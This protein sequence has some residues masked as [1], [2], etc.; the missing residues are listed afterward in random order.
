MDHRD[1]DREMP[2]CITTPC[3]PTKPL[4]GTCHLTLEGRLQ[5]PGG[6]QPPFLL[7]TG[8]RQRASHGCRSPQPH[9]RRRPAANLTAKSML[10]C[11]SRPWSECGS[12]RS[13]GKAPT[14]AHCQHS[15]ALRRIL[16]IS[17]SCVCNDRQ[18]R[19]TKP[20]TAVSSSCQ[21]LQ[22]VL[23]WPNTTA[24]TW[25]GQKYTTKV[26]NF[27]L[28]L[29]RGGKRSPN[30]VSGSPKRYSWFGFNSR[31]FSQNR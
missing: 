15:V 4:C 23:K 12:R 21:P 6:A 16:S 3:P 24:S 7:A 25:D 29:P 31:P 1:E 8:P 14:V 26:A 2:R 19:R 18:Q 27:G 22:S 5:A 10:H 17:S 20:L 13:A 11:N 9:R 28:G 30:L